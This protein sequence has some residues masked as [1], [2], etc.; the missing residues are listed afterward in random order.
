MRSCVLRLSLSMVLSLC[1]LGTLSACSDSADP[2]TGPTEPP[3]SSNGG[4]DGEVF[5]TGTELRVPVPASGRVF[6]KLATIPVTLVLIQFLLYSIPDNIQMLFS[7]V[8]SG[9][10]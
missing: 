3:P 9:L 7:L 2:A 4:S 10:G 5:D 1:G 8:V 6:V